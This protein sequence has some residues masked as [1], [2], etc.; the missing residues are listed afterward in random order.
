MIKDKT[1]QQ[2]GVQQEQS[3]LQCLSRQQAQLS[4]SRVARLRGCSMG[5]GQ[6]TGLVP[7]LH[8][9]L[10]LVVGLFF[11][12]VCCI[13]YSPHV[14]THMSS[15]C[16]PPHWLSHTGVSVLTDSAVNWKSQQKRQTA[17]SQNTINRSHAKLNNKNTSSHT[18]TYRRCVKQDMHFKI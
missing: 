13:Q 15:H 18:E 8:P 1:S 11:C 14:S 3:P 6:F 4:S 17:N 16:A 7:E 2:W 12:C 10:G 9:F 5:P